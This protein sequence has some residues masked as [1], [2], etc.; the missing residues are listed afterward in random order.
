MYL[1]R[2]ELDTARKQT[3]IA[4]VSRNKFHGAIENAF[5]RQREN[6]TRNLWRIDRLGGKTYLLL[7]SQQ[8]PN[9]S[10]FVKQFGNS[11]TNCET[12]EYDVLLNK[13][14]AQSVWR[15]RVIANPTRCV[16][17]GNGRGKRVAH[18]T[19]KYQMEWFITQ[20]EKNGFQIVEDKLQIMD[21][22]WLMFNKRGERMIRA[23][24]VTYEGVLMV[25]D[26]Q[27]FKKV[28][29]SGI[30]REKAYGMGMLTIMRAD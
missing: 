17:R 2:I 27:K 26:V 19:V 30:G 14:T 11:T 5:S 3:Q 13:I 21:S 23:L 20:A 22:A 29:V 8:M 7:L 15:F 18:T 16:A 25:N 4:L 9:L 12:K 1:S 28:L 24:A 10:D 6:Q